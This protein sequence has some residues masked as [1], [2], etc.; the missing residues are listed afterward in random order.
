EALTRIHGL[1]CVDGEYE[2]RTRR[3]PVQL[4]KTGQTSATAKLDKH[5]IQAVPITNEQA[6]MDIRQFGRE[7][8]VPQVEAMR[9]EINHQVMKALSAADR[10]ATN[11]ETRTGAD[12]CD[13]AVAADLE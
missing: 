13:V 7:I 12:R 6:T 11:L 8:V 1:F 4:Q 2:W 5:L 9:V 3:N 10:K